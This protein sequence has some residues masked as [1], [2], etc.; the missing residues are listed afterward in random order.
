LR[1]IRGFAGGYVLRRD[2][3]GDHVGDHAGEVEFVV[4]NFFESVEAVKAFAGEDY[5]VP[6]F[7]HD[8]VVYAFTGDLD[9][10][11]LLKLVASARLP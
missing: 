11:R 9:Q 7:E 1:T 4:L 6:V 10:Q 3:M 5:T 8:G 2:Q